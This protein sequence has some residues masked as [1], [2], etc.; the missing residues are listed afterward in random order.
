[1]SNKDFHEA[2]DY[3]ANAESARIHN[4]LGHDYRKRSQY[5]EALKAYGS[6]LAS[7]P[8]NLE[9]HQN[10]TDLLLEMSHYRELSSA[11]RIAL[12][13]VPENADMHCQTAR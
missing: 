6:A 7:Q 8:E 1:M 9:A 2:D 11:C 3:G 10:L 13:Y 12:Q 5:S 4:R